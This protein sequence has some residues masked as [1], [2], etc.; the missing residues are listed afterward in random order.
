MR[1]TAA[2]PAPA[3][4]AEPEVAEEPEPGYP[5][6]QSGRQARVKPPVLTLKSASG[7]NVGRRASV[8]LGMPTTTGPIAADAIAAAVRAKVG[9]LKTCYANDASNASPAKSVVVYT[10]GVSPDGKVP[11]AGSSAQVLSV[12]LDACVKRVLRSLTF[13][14]AGRGST[15]AVNLPLVFDSTGTIAALVRPKGPQPDPWTPFARESSAVTQ[16]TGAVRVSEAAVRSRIDQIEQ[17][18]ARPTPTGSLRMMLELDVMG[19]LDQVRIGGLGDAAIEAC[20]A[21][22]LAGLHVVTPTPNAVEVACDL[23]RGDAQPW[24]I[25]PAAGYEVIEADRAKLRHG[26]DLLV[27][28]GTDPDP[29]PVNTYLVLAQ[30]DTPGALLRLALMWANEAETVLLAVRDGNSPPLYLGIGHI[31]VTQGDDSEDSDALRPAL[32]VGA[33]TVTGCV[34]RGTHEAKLSDPAAVGALV[35]RLASR[36]HTLGCAPTLL[37]AI[38]NDAVARDLIEITGAARRAGFDRV[39]LGGS[40]LGCQITPRAPRPRDPIIDAPDYE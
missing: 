9:E 31:S 13:P 1:C 18:F 33:K 19:E 25:T 21:K 36:C 15:V 17:C 35:Q 37:V 40:E 39:L 38:D 14:A 12:P 20:V 23:A 6:A 5:W 26:D 4:G 28:G 11:Y 2:L 10:F 7:V 29:L 8:S 22:A 27:P 3:I 32:R 30:R 34:S 24:R 16:A